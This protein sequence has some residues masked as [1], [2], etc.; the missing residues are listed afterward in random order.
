MSYEHV[1]WEQD[2]AVGRVTLNRPDSLNAWTGDFGRELK[3][4]V[5]GDAADPAAASPR[6]RT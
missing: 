2:G 6:A 4:V 5:E 3:Q 1:I